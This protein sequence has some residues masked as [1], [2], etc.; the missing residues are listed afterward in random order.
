L[1]A[2]KRAL[3]DRLAEQRQAI[4]TQAVTKG[5]NPAAPMKDSGVEWLG[6]VPAHWKVWPLKRVVSCSTYGVSASLEPSGDV[7]I[8]RMGNLQG[9]ELDFGDLRYLD[10]VE[11]GLM[12]KTRDVIFNRTNSLDLVG[13]A[14]IYRGNYEGDLS[15]ASYLVL[16]RF[17]ERYDPDFANYVMGTDVLMSFGRTLALPSI[18]QAN[19]NPNRYAAISFPV[20]PIEEQLDIAAHIATHLAR[21]S[22]SEE[23]TVASIGH[24]IEYRAALITAAVTG[25]IEELR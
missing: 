7:A 17:D 24:L 21:L 23:A 15:L 18:G 12:I 9:G 2:K 5:M 11:P 25:Q 8:L 1:I 20:P 19:L 13:K 4:I 6:Q 16:F 3:Q 22:D 10:H 14:A